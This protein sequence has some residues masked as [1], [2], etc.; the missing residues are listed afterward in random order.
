MS[1]DNVA[2]IAIELSVTSWLVVARLPGAEKPRLHRIEGGDT[3]A[4]ARVDRRAAL[5]RVGQ[6][7]RAR[8]GSCRLDAWRPAGVQLV[9]VPTPDEEG[10]KRPHRERAQP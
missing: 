3:A 6:G 1:P 10:A 2:Y 9:R 4:L 5:T 7:R 8:E